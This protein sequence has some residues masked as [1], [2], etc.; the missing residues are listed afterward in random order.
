[1]KKL[2][3]QKNLRVVTLLVLLY[4]A[5]M[6]ISNVI[7]IILSFLDLRNN[8][9]IPDYLISY[10]AF[11]SYFVIPFFG[12]IIYLMSLQ[13]NSKHLNNSIVIGCFM[14]CAIYYF[15]WGDI[16]LFIHKFNPYVK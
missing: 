7:T 13:L 1:M 8:P 11:P 4:A 10:M 14:V 16:H 3:S 5:L 9:L 15:F 6:I 12:M 2:L